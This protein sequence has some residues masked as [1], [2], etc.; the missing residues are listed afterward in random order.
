[1][2]DAV[3]VWIEVFEINVMIASLIRV[4]VIIIG[5]VYVLASHEEPRLPKQNVGG[6]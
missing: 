4:V 1:M 3:M 6:G 2:V 5:Y